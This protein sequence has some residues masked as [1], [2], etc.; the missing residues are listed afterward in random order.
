MDDGYEW[1]YF[2]GAIVQ[3]AFYERHHGYLVVWLWN[4]EASQ[5]Y[6]GVSHALWKKLDEGLDVDSVYL[7]EILGRYLCE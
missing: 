1:K 5:S 7:K 6:C 4:T 3:R 2:R